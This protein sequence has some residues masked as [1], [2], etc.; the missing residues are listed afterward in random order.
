MI[1]DARLNMHLY[2]NGFYHDMYV[3]AYQVISNWEQSTI[4]WNNRASYSSTVLDYEKFVKMIR[5]LGM[6][7]T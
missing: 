3:G 2:M 1:V 7:G 4:T 5:M 6:T